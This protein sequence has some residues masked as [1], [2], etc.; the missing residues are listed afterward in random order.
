VSPGA[1]R[2]ELVGRHGS[3]WKV[4]VVAAPERGRANEAVL[5]LLAG[6]LRV[7]RGR[8]RVVA[9]TSARDKVIEVEGMRDDEADRLLEAGSGKGRA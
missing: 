5:E 8:L 3:A 2:T 4:R 1:K 7:P 9:G 6:A